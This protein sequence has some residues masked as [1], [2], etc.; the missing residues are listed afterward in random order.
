MLRTALRNVLAH[1]TR[2]LMTVLAVC[3]GVTFITGALVFADST[4]AAY[5][6]A[7]SRDYA[8]IAVSVTPAYRPGASGTE[9][10][11]VLD[12]ALVRK[13][14]SVTGVAS[15]RPAADG[16][17]TLSAKDG[18][19]MRADSLM[20]KFG[21]AYVPGADGKDSRYPLTAGRAPGAAVRSRWTGAPR[22]PP[23]MPSATPS[24]SPRTGRS[25]TSAWWAWCPP[26]TAG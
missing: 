8:D 21:A 25:S 20:G 17:V 24:H 10:Y 15:A 1:R 2:L 22:P 19:P 18:T 7:M 12:D 23:A 9:Q 3:L 5:R 16:S 13:L 26:T 6:A 11:G 14:S 4:T